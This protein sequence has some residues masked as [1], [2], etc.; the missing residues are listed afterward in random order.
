MT[1]PVRP[2]RLSPEQRTEFD[3]LL[4][5]FE[6][7]SQHAE[8]A[9]VGYA[10]KRQALFAYVRGLENRPSLAALA[11][12]APTPTPTP[13]PD[14][15]RVGESMSDDYFQHAAECP[16][17]EAHEAAK[18]A[19]PVAMTPTGEQLRDALSDILAAVAGARGR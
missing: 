14:Q 10:Q 2:A 5:A 16:D 8:P 9:T 11:S 13:I 1:T 6:Q 19:T 4:N 12:T 3:Y 15:C 18:V 17:C 7:A